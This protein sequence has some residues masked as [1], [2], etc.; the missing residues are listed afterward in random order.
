MGEEYTRP[1]RS[2]CGEIRKNKRPT[3]H[4]IL[5]LKIV[6]R[7]EI[8]TRA[9]VKILLGEKDIRGKKF[10]PLPHYLPS[11]TNPPT[12]YLKR[13]HLQDKNNASSSKAI[14]SKPFSRTLYPVTLPTGTCPLSHEFPLFPHCVHISVS[15][16]PTNW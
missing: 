9:G 3:L 10:K 2:E 6:K 1:D 15:V 13:D 16:C 11:H 12:P 4:N 14:A 5:Q 8:D 7:W